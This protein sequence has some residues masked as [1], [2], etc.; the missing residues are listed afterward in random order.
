MLNPSNSLVMCLLQCWCWTDR[1]VHCSW[2][3]DASDQ[4]HSYS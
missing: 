4:R 3:Y 1:D 2:Q